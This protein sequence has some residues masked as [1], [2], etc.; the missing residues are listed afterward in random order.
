MSRR[1]TERTACHASSYTS[2]LPQRLQL[3]SNRQSRHTQNTPEKKSRLPGPRPRLRYC[4]TPSSLPQQRT[5]TSSRRKHQ[6]DQSFQDSVLKRGTT[7]K[8]T[9]PPDPTGGSGLSPEGLDPEEL[10]V[11]FPLLL[12]QAE[13]TYLCLCPL[14]NLYVGDLWFML[15]STCG[16]E[17][18]LLN[19][20]M[21]IFYIC[22]PPLQNFMMKNFLVRVVPKNIYF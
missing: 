13:P 9:P 7:L 11:R 19:F 10:A 22:T 18:I 20:A 16:Y 8:T 15:N 6:R 17:L 1:V 2:G 12:A 5:C 21:L 3:H 14:I 4:S